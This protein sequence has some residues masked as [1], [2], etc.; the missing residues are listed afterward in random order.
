MVVASVLTLLCLVALAAARRGGVVAQSIPENDWALRHLAGEASRLLDRIRR[1]TDPLRLGPAEEHHVDNY[2]AGAFFFLHDF[3][4][5]GGWS[6]DEVRRM[7]GLADESNAAVPEA[8]KQEVVDQVFAIYDENKN[9]VIEK[10]EF[11]RK[12]AAGIRLP[13]FGVSRG[14]E[15]AALRSQS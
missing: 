7:Y 6:P 14:N 3:D 11:V 2:N 1:I 12:D 13:D 15:K 8:K 4:S 5:S 9:G 10:D